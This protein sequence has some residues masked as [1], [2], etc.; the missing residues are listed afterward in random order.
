V[1]F[2]E[3]LVSVCSRG[4]CCPPCIP[5]VFVCNYPVKLIVFVNIT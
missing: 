5:V 4:I 2:H 1:V 3:I